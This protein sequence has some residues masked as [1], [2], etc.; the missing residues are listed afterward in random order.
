MALCSKFS[1]HNTRSCTVQLL[2][3]RYKAEGS[4]K[5]TD[6]FMK[7]VIIDKEGLIQGELHTQ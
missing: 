7:P 1:V 3:R 4:D 5:Q 6:E 2:E